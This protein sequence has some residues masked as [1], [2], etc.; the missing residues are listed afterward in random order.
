[1]L[2][3]IEDCLFASIAA[4][5]FGSISNVPVKAFTGCAILAAAGHGTRTLLTGHLDIG[6]IPASLV[7]SLIIGLL[8]IPVASHWKAPAESMSF[9][10]LLPMIPGMYAYR[11]IQALIACLQHSSET[12]FMHQLYLLNYNGL[13]C[14]TI[15]LLM[16]LGVTVPIF[17]FKRY[18]FSATR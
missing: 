2:P 9:P 12:D 15:I 10:A 11:A 6:I 17:C 16:F 1:M 14:C 5:G 13:I 7:G 4:I 3:F 8:S 18:S